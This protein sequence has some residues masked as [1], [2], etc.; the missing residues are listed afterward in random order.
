MLLQSKPSATT[1]DQ[2]TRLNQSLGCLLAVMI[3]VVAAS[4]GASKPAHVP[5]WVSAAAQTSMPPLRPNDAAAVLLD[6]TDIS[7]DPQGHALVHRREVIR[8]LTASGR[9][10]AMHRLYYDA[11]SKVRQLHSW[12]L[13][14]DGRE[15]Q[16]D[17][18]NVSDFA[19]VPEFAVFASERVRIAEALDAEPGS[20]VAFESEYTEAPY[21]T[22]WRFDLDREI[23]SAGSTVTMTLP[24]GFTHQESWAHLDAIAPES[25][26][27]SAWRWR[28]GPRMSI[29]DEQ[30]APQWGEMT[31]R[32]LLTY[33]GGPVAPADGDWST[34]GT[35]FDGLFRDRTAASPEIVSEVAALTAGK[36]SYSD[37]LLAITGFLQ[38]QI[39]YVA[40]EMGIGG[41]QPHPARD[42]FHNRYGDC[43]DK[44]TLLITML[45]EAGIEAYPL[46]VDFNHS[47]DPAMPTHF[48]NHMITAIVVPPDVQDPE[49]HAV[50]EV[51]G[52]RLL[53]FDP[54]NPVA[55]AG[56]L[57]P[58]LQGTFGLL[59]RGDSSRPL[60]LPVLAPETN[61]IERTATFTLLPDGSVTGDV[62]EI[63]RGNTADI[64]RELYLAGDTRKLEQWEE[65]SLG[66]SLANFTMSGLT[67]SHGT[68]RTHPLE[69]HYHVAASGYGKHAGPLLLVR[70]AVLG[71]YRPVTADTGKPRLY[72]LA[73][74][75]EQEIHE[76]YAI[77]LPPG[78]QEDALP[79]AVE[80][81]TSF[82][83]FESSVKLEGNTLHYERKLKVSKLELPADEYGQYLQFVRDV[84]G[85]ERSQ[86]VLRPGAALSDVVQGPSQK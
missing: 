61:A 24:P 6:E 43:K 9:G 65:R 14:A 29:D 69:V 50:V 3:L 84:S 11:G 55:P 4:A 56:S 48:A 86:A 72:P 30:A 8:I 25:T 5:D 63:R 38:D 44:A 17:D 27:P 1:A 58:E 15:Y 18:K 31:A 77:Q 49:L 82:A 36:T 78:Y 16:L 62:V 59:L 76:K 42:V 45:R 79:D 51:R 60:Q 46:M 54:T 10:Y 28:T 19:A 71:L 41:W 74:G 64:P 26:G 52:K 67:L 40:V 68:E 13:G 37:R 83:V 66:Q 7:V 22:S 23:P 47:V 75:Q 53:I 2:K 35:W 21:L 33:S 73:I 85:A 81:R 12:T 39:R 20:T 57:E 80:V 70:P 34:V 32:M